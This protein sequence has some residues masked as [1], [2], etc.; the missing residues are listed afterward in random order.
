MNGARALYKMF[1]LIQ[2][3]YDDLGS[4]ENAVQDLKV[5]A[6]PLMEFCED[7]VAND[8]ETT[9]QK[10]VVKWNETND[11]LKQ[12]CEKYKGAVKLWRQYCDDSEAIRNVIDQYYGA[13]DDLAD[14]KSLEEI[15]VRMFFKNLSDPI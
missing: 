9:M 15:Q 1:S 13:V 11:N 14:E 5:Y 6:Q 7:H 12:I 4:R 10:A 3:L 8:I 2:G